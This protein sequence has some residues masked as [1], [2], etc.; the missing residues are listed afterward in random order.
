M[1][2]KMVFY[3]RANNAIYQNKYSY[4]QKLAWITFF[5]ILSIFFLWY[6]VALFGIIHK[7]PSDY[8]GLGNLNLIE[9]IVNSFLYF[10]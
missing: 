7:F 10:L 4:S 1:Y 5:C 8:D 3:K 9:E 6:E 2:K